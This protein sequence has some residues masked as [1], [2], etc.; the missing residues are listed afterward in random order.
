MTSPSAPCFLRSL[1]RPEQR[2]WG[3]GIAR[4]GQGHSYQAWVRGRARRREAV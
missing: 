1:A 3:V 2:R 4:R